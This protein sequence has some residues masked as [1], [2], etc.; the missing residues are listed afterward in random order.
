MGR[1]QT[2]LWSKYNQ[3]LRTI[4]K[5]GGTKLPKLRFCP[6]NFI[7][8]KVKE[9]GG[10]GQV[11]WINAFQQQKTAKARLLTI[12]SVHSIW[13][14]GRA[15]REE[16]VT[17]NNR[18]RTWHSCLWPTNMLFVSSNP[19]FG[20]KSTHNVPEHQ[21]RTWDPKNAQETN[22]V[23]IKY[24]NKHTANPTLR[25]WDGTS[26]VYLHILMNRADGLP[27]Q[28]DGAQPVRWPPSELSAVARP[29]Q[30]RQSE[31]TGVSFSPGKTECATW[32]AQ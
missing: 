4:G 25:H 20:K 11:S 9:V 32:R 16:R 24:Q 22:L 7:K 19:K 5:S 31:A 18:A 8:R 1:L 2:C 21:T 27:K 17:L 26:R 28:R 23:H 6:F 14:I 29:G 12:S 10:W 30:W 15:F 13:Y 3:N